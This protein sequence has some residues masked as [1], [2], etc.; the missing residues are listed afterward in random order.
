MS[1][2]NGKSKNVSKSTYFDTDTGGVFGSSEKKEDKEP[3]DSDSDEDDSNNRN[4]DESN[5]DSDAESDESDVSD[6]DDDGQQQKRPRSR[7]SSSPVKISSPSRSGN[8]IKYGT[9]GGNTSGQ[10]PPSP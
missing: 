7:R 4:P 9:T 5:T 6:S 2:R 1:D 10:R 8:P 3:I